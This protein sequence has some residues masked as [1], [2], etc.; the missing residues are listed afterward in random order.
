[1]IAA[2]YTIAAV[3]MVASTSV[4]VNLAAIDTLVALAVA[5]G[6]RLVALP[7]NAAIMGR[8]EFAKV[9]IRESL[10]G[11]PIQ[12]RLAAMAR[13]HQIWLI[14][15]TIPLAADA[16]RKARAGCLVFD[17]TGTRVACY[18][19][20]HLFSFSQGAERYDEGNSHEAGHAPV[21]LESPFGR[22]ALSICY[23]LRFPE[24]YRQ[25]APFDVMFVPSAFT[26]T[27]GRAHWEILLRARAIENLAFVVAAAQ[28]GRHENA[29][30]TWGHSMLVDPWG[31]VIAQ[32]A[33]EPGVVSAELAFARIESC[34]AQLP[35][36]E[37]R[38]L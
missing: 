27:T 3:Q 14:A 9:D 18:E 8:D 17:D 23:D 35:A 4:D 6:A 21:A 13:Q 7:E 30:R 15:G 2:P 22:L 36:L 11:G 28:G 1:M 32:R 26:A 25:L 31:A 5:R 12:A 34:R 37:H 20:I 16:P 19:K 38:M 10:D 29:R 33:Q 24:L